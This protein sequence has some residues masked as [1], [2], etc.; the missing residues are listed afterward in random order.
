MTTHAL[1]R[2]A[3]A[4]TLVALA[5]LAA[6]ACGG[7]DDDEASAETTEAESSETTETTEAAA[8]EGG[9]GVDASDPDEAAVAEAWTTVFDSSVAADAKAPFLED[10]AAAAPTLAAYATTGQMMQGIT[11]APTDVTVDG[12]TATV[13]Y[14]ILFAG[15]PAYEDQTGEVVKLDGAWKVTTEQFCSFMATARTPCA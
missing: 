11:L 15:T 4:L 12:D 14:D 8:E 9:A 5:P 6:A 10:P 3:A 2:R 13:T 7:D 1:A